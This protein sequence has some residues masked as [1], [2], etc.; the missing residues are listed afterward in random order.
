[1]YVPIALSDMNHRNS[2]PSIASSIR[3][4]ALDMGLSSSI[5]VSTAAR[6][7]P[8]AI[9]SFISSA[10][11]F[12]FIVKNSTSAEMTISTDAMMNGSSIIQTF[13]ASSAALI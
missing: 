12:S 8:S 5:G 13:L 11:L 4:L 1:M 2:A 6:R 10:I 9:S 7:S 3:L